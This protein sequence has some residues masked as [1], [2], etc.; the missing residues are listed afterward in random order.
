MKTCHRFARIRADY[1][2][3]AAY[4]RNYA[5]R[6]ENSPRAKTSTKRAYLTRRRMARAL[7]SHVT[8]CLECG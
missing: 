4:L 5:A 7:S 8:H 2:R 3:E 6:N 1:E